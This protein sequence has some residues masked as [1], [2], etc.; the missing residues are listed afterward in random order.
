MFWKHD[1]EES[2]SE[3]GSFKLSQGWEGAWERDHLCKGF[4]AGKERAGGE[5]TEMG[6]TGPEHTGLCRPWPE[7]WLL[8]QGQLEATEGF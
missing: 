8:F 4:A 1:V 3:E 2:F 7:A 5:V 6:W